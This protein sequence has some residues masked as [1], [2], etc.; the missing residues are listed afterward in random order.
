[1][2]HYTEQG[3]KLA[4]I[5]QRQDF[6]KNSVDFFL[7]FRR[8]AK[9]AQEMVHVVHSDSSQVGAGQNIQVPPHVCF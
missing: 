7:R 6:A 4:D 9:V 3:E 8:Q 2:R 1:M 5:D